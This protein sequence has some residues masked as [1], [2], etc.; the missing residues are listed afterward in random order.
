MAGEPLSAPYARGGAGGWSLRAQNPVLVGTTN[1]SAQFEAYDSEHPLDQVDLFIDGK[2]FQTITN[3][4]PRAGDQLNV[5][6]DGYPIV[7]TTPLNSSITSL[8]QGLAAQI[9]TQSNL[10]R[11]IAIP[12]GDRIEL[13]SVATNRMIE[14]VYYNDSTT[15]GARYY[16]GV[17]LPGAAPVLTS[18]GRDVNGVYRLHVASPLK[19]GW[20]IEAS[21][22]LRQWAQI[23]TT[24]NG[25]PFD[26]WD[27]A[28]QLLPARF[29]RISQNLPDRRIT[30]TLSRPVPGG[31]NLHLDASGIFP[32]EIQSST[33]LKNW[34]SYA[35]N[36]AGGAMDALLPFD[37]AVPV[38]YFRG[39]AFSTAVPPHIDPV[40]ANLIRATG[41]TSQPYRIEVSTNLFDWFALATN[42]N[43]G[44]TL[45]SA[46][47]TGSNGGG[48]LVRLSAARSYFIDSPANGYQLFSLSGILQ[49]ATWV[50]FQIT[51]T[52]GVT[53]NVGI[54]N[55]GTAQNLMDMGYAIT[56]AINTS[57]D[58]QGN[59]G[60]IAGDLSLNQYNGPRFTLRAR[61]AGWDAARIQV[62]LLGSSRLALNPATNATLTANL[63]D[64]QPRDHLYVGC[65]TTNLAGT[66]SLDTR[67]LADGTHELTAVAYEGTSVRS[68]TRATTTVIVSNS[69]LSAI[70]TRLDMPDSTPASG[71]YHVQVQ[72]G[73]G[74]A[75]VIHLMSTGG[76]IGVSSNTPLATFAVDAVFLGAGRHPFYAITEMPDGRKYQTAKQWVRLTGPP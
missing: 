36:M 14:A 59:D 20:N 50:L 49:S 25:G 72:A 15:S 21:T 62:K 61:S 65:G 41:F 48:S 75:A 67:L 6:L 39:N 16:R 73:P 31:L 51:K 2:Y 44:A 17:L 58:L 35:T 76:E 55:N 33:D 40:S 56:N 7:Y 18:N 10:T 11:V 9:N 8:A 4:S 60:V 71:T 52:N 70:F 26:F 47:A 3:L 74:P 28:S 69:P 24:A 38:R 46:S 30:L 37:A 53:V 66:I 22:D 27:P 34:V 1:L 29:Y 43:P 45:L 5:A 32:Y 13:R 63:S 12:A 19:T 57:P 54:T 68:Q 23:Y 42:S 64:L